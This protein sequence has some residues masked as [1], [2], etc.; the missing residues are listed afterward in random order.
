MQGYAVEGAERMERRDR[1]IV[2]ACLDMLDTDARFEQH[3][4]LRQTPLQ[5]Q[6]AQPLGYVADKLFVSGKSYHNAKNLK[7]QIH[8]DVIDLR[9]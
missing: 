6:F 7:S 8:Y 5:T 3:L 2:A 1:D 4:L 9:G